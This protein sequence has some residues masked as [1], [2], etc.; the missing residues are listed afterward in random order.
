MRLFGATVVS[1]AADFASGN[2]A[3]GFFAAVAEARSA[4]APISRMAA[5]N[6]SPRAARNA[7]SMSANVTYASRAPWRDSR[8][9]VPA[10]MSPQRGTSVS[11]CGVQSGVSPALPSARIVATASAPATRASSLRPAAISSQRWF[12]SDCGVFPPQ[13]VTRRR[14]GRTP[15]RS[16]SSVAVSP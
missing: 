6:D 16:A 14:A 5:S 7:F 10:R 8:S 3:Y 12:T 15:R 4:N 2:H 13:V 11:R 9:L 1:V